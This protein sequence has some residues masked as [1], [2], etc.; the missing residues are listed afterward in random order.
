MPDNIKLIPKSFCNGDVIF[1]LLKIFFSFVFYRSHSLHSFIFSVFLSLFMSRLTPSS[2][3][4]Q[5]SL[6]IALLSWLSSL[7]L[8]SL[9][10]FLS[11]L[12]Y[13]L[14]PLN[15]LPPISLLTKGG[16][17]RTFFFSLLLFSST[18]FLSDLYLRIR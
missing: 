2:S 16:I 1:I 17:I 6:L 13:P 18:A 15:F 14:C 12:F 4:P 3:F 11:S 5:L 8:L 10:C 9:P 7:N